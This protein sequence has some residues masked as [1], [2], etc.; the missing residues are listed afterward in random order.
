MVNTNQFIKI[1]LK[2]VQFQCDLGM[3]Y[4][5]PNHSFVNKWLLLCNPDNALD[6]HKGYLKICVSL[7]GP[8]NE[9]PV[10]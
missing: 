4:G 2:F 9:A 3:I 10:C 7:L 5:E 1:R 8:G 6:S